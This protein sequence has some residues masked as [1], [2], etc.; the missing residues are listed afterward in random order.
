MSICTSLR[1]NAR[2]ASGHQEGSPY[3]RYVVS[4]SIE[5]LLFPVCLRF[6]V[7]RKSPGDFT[8][9]FTGDFKSLRGPFSTSKRRRVVAPA[10]RTGEG[11]ASEQRKTAF[12][13]RLKAFPWPF[14]AMPEA[15]PRDGHVAAMEGAPGHVFHRAAGKPAP[16]QQTF[17]G[18]AGFLLWVPRMNPPCA[19][20][21]HECLMSGCAGN[22][23]WCD[24]SVYW[25]SR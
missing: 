7:R 8:G 5:A 13:G 1:G 12:T 21:A 14:D 25:G 9:D 4:W 2:P 24:L 6:R 3:L 18:K 22:A 15:V 10:H 16:P 11:R 20:N 23:E 19:G 17:A